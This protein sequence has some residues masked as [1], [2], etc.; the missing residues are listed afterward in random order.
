M[1]IEIKN[2]SN[3]VSAI[4][5]PFGGWAI[6][7]TAL[8]C[9][10]ANLQARR[11]LQQEAAKISSKLNDIGHEFKL[12]E[13]SYEKYLDLLLDYYSVFYRHYRLCQNATNQDAHLFDNGTKIKTK[14]IFFEQLGNYISELNDWEGKIRLVL[15]AHLLKL[16]EESITAFNEFKDVMKQTNYSE[17]FH[18]AKKDAFARIIDIK[19]KLEEGLRDFLRTERLLT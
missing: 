11:I 17:D 14:D 12:R 7:V 19:N 5:V 9:Y 2:W 15:P 6:V 13:S 8:I 4:L 16:H 10:L 3:F 18:S 1:I